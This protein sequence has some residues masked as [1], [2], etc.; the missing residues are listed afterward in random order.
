MTRSM[1]S[2]EGVGAVVGGWLMND[3]LVV[4]IGIE[5]SLALLKL[6]EKILSLELENVLEHERELEIISGVDNLK[7]PVIEPPIN[8]G[9]N[10]W[11]W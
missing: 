2:S 6:E 11:V 9:G 8:L 5:L 10:A 3:Q 1:K 4:S 7:P